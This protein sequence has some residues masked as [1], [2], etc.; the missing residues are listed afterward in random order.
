[1]HN[2]N[3]LTDTTELYV[4]TMTTTTLDIWNGNVSLSALCGSKKLGSAKDVIN[5]NYK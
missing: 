5:G 4:Y 2:W 3:H 1:M